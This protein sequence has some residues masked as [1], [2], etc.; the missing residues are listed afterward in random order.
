M[1]LAVVPVAETSLLP[2]QACLAL[3][4]QHRLYSSLDEFLPELPLLLQQGQELDAC[5]RLN[6]LLGVIEP[7][8]DRH[9]PPDGLQVQGPNYRESLMARGCLSRHRAVLLVL[10]QLFGDLEPVQQQRT[11]LVEAV[12][13][14]ALW[15]KQHLPLLTLSEFFDGGRPSDPAE[16]IPH[17]DLC[18]LTFADRSFD[19]VI[20]NE[21]FEHVYD[22]PQAL[23]EIL[24]VLRPGGRL[25]AT[26]PMAFGQRD[27]VIKARWNPTSATPD[28]I[29]QPD[30][31]GDPIRPDQ[32]SLVYQ[33]PGWE[34]LDQTREAGFHTALIHAVTSWKH[35][36]LGGDISGVLV[37]EAQR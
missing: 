4:H 26:F 23:R 35:G 5:A 3:H 30:F 15:M 17:Q 10:Q 13:G 7:L 6:R 11:Y 12:T 33:I 16:T 20:C 31:H 29:G 14:F 25:L 24:R 8:T 27:S 21:L 37:M 32:G 36:V 28:I 18:R 22:L 2:S 34:L 19:L 1:G 9:L